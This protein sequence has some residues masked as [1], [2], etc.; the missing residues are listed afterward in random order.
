MA[1]VNK[2][3]EQEEA[4]LA[5]QRMA[6][7]VAL[8]YVELGTCDRRRRTPCGADAHQHL[9]RGDGE[10]AADQGAAT[11]MPPVAHVSISY[12]VCTWNNITVYPA[13][14][15]LESSGLLAP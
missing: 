4:M 13:S 15:S 6:A 11:V 2:A 5:V 7:M 9:H 12:I 1:E 8:F 3:E 14:T 10:W